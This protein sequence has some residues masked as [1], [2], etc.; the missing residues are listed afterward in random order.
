MKKRVKEWISYAIKDLNSAKK[1]SEDPSLNQNAAF[2]CQQAVE[3]I[4]KA[5]IENYK[6]RTPRI[7]DLEKLYGIIL[8]SGILITIDENILAEINDVYIETRYPP[9]LGLMPNGIPSEE[10]IRKFIDEIEATI[11]QVKNN[12]DK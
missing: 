8:E 7:H 6:S 5:V 11:E 2:H 1:L 4:L 12:I 10:T 9:D 3:K